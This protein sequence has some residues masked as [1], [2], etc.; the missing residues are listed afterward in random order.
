MYFTILLIVITS[1]I[2]YLGITKDFFQ[3]RYYFNIEKVFV[4]K[5]YYRL[6]TSGFLHI[7][8]MHLA[9]NMFVL[10]SFG[11]GLESALGVLPFLVIY[12]VSLIGGNLLA[13]LI[14]KQDEQYSSVG[15]SG[16][17]SGL[18]FATIAI[19]PG[20][21]IFFIPAWIYG[22]LYVLYTIYAIRSQRTD[23][24]HAA[25]LGGALIGMLAAILMFPAALTNN[26]L[27][28]LAI[29]VPGIAL[30][31]IMIYNPNL[32]LINKHTRHE[33]LTIEDKYN[34]S[35]KHEKEEIDRILEKINEK[36]IN[37]LSKKE[38]QTLDDYSKS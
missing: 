3:E 16:A 32:I 25:H 19:M 33:Q 7:S 35:K 1:V 2:S 28:I 14:H 34:L 38:K 30:I 27:P 9:I 20:L 11:S 6:V 18:V 31:V 21:K 24:G 13:I 15:A 37:S 29:I 8:W 4:Y 17:I 12:F 23:V 26:F 10:F 5:Q 22:V 36:G